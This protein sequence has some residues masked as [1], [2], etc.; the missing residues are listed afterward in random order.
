MKK[1]NEDNMK[2]YLIVAYNHQNFKQIENKG[3]EIAWTNEFSMNK[4]LI[5]IN[6]YAEYY[7]F[8]EKAKKMLQT[9]LVLTK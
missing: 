4:R 3:N 6:E 9:K 5:H 8:M 1:R 2:T 7:N